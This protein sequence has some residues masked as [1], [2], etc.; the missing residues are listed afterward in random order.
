MAR[1]NEAASRVRD[2]WV[3]S[4]LDVRPVAT[5]DIVRLSRRFAG[6]GIADYLQFLSIAGLPTDEDANAFRFWT[7]RELA[8]ASEVLMG[9]GYSSAEAHTEPGLVFADHMQES[10]WYK[11]CLEGAD[12]GQIRRAGSGQRDRQSRS[13]GSMTDFL[14]AYLRDDDCLYPA[15]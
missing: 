3:A 1:I 10:W 8:Q 13:I 14:E 5:S 15:E 6:D 9:A 2:Y 7:P 4:G 12:V 11:I